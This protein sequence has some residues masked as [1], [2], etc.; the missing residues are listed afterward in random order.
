MYVVSMTF[1]GVWVAKLVSISCNY[2]VK[3]SNNKLIHIV[4]I[5]LLIIFCDLMQHYTFL[6]VVVS[7]LWSELF[8]INVI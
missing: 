3:C 5:Y 6:C 7:V 2:K 4:I 1:K 8:I